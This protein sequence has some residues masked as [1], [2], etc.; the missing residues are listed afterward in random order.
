MPSATSW[1][2]LEGIKLSESSQRQIL[3]V[4]YMRNLK[5]KQTTEYNYKRNQLTD[6]ENKVVVITGKR[7]VR[8]SRIGVGD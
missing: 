7:E 4:I 5:I 2:E 6:I 3:Y 8:R 1:V